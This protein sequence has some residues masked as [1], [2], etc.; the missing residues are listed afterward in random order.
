MIVRL[1]QHICIVGLMTGC[2]T[3]TMPSRLPAGWG[4]ERL[5]ESRFRIFM[6][7]PEEQAIRDSLYVASAIAGSYGFRYFTFVED[8]GPASGRKAAWQ[9]HHGYTGRAALV[10]WHPGQSFTIEGRKE[11]TVRGGHIDASAQ[12]N[13]G[14]PSAARE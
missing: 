11:P 6:S 5:T 4:Y 10:L 8:A 12:M 2:M 3:N 7:V 9:W 14:K 1:I 13:A